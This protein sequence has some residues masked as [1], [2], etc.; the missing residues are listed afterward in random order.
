LAIKVIIAGL[1]PRG[2]DW[3]REVRSSLGFELAGCVEIDQQVRQ[4]AADSLGIP[5]AS[6]FD[7]L[8]EAISKTQCQ[9]VIVATSPKDHE[10]SC[11]TAIANDLAVLV[12]KPFTLRLREAVRL[13]ELAEQK[14]T[15]LLVAQNYRYMR[16]FRTV[17]RIIDEGKLGRINS[18]TCQYFR[19]PHQ[20][21]ASLLGLEHSILYGMSVHHLDALRSI[22]GKEIHSVMAE[23]F[24]ASDESPAGASFRALLA[25][26]DGPRLSYFATYESSGFEF[27][28]RGQQFYARFVGERGTLHVFQR[29]LVFSERGKLPRMVSRGKRHTTE[30]QILLQQLERA[31]LHGDSA[32]VSGRDN[33]QT[34]ALLEACMQSSAE[35]K[36]INPQDLLND[37]ESK[38]AVAGNR[39]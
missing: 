24:A 17:R 23:S 28:E 36:W 30:E 37:A 6:C 5:R 15:P 16:A 27:F 3:V 8:A 18:I 21:A 32:E 12:E 1:G 33:L 22:L 4:D 39:D 20:M 25:F 38:Y 2:C 29:W 11:E 14:Q 13:V 35:R 31:I 7:D 34:M 10:R 19:P 26:E 9:A